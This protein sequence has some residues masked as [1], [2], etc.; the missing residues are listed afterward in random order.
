ML[1]CWMAST[2]RREQINEEYSMQDKSLTCFTFSFGG[3]NA[4]LRTRNKTTCALNTCDI[5]LYFITECEGFV[6]LKCVDFEIKIIISCLHFYNIF[7]DTSILIVDCLDEQ[8]RK[9][10][11]N[12]GREWT[13]KCFNESWNRT[14]SRLHA[15]THLQ[16]ISHYYYSYYNY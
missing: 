5:W 3:K 9:R 12:E 15:H 10:W 1:D 8:R 13:Q 11:R 4:Y 2:R 6:L 14:K 16:S 7:H